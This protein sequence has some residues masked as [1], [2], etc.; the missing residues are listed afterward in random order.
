MTLPALKED[1][2]SGYLSPSLFVKG[3]GLFVVVKLEI[4]LYRLNY[5]E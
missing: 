5:T 4:I 1:L 3:K 2:C